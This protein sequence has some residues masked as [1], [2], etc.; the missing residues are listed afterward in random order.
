MQQIKTIDKQ[1][2]REFGKQI[3][4]IREHRGITLKELSQETGLSRPL[5]DHYELGC[6]KIKPSNWE[7]ISSALNISSSIKI[8]VTLG[9]LDV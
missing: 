3:R 1:F 2:Y 9:Y 5:L 6:S 7:K 8:D 4:K